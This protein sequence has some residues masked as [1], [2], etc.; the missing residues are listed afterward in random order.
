MKHTMVGLISLRRAVYILHTP[1]FHLPYRFTIM[2]YELPHDYRCVEIFKKKKNYYFFIWSV[3]HMVELNYLSAE[4]TTV[5]VK[6]FVCLCFSVC[7]CLFFVVV[8]VVLFSFC[9]FC[10]VFLQKLYVIRNI[11]ERTSDQFLNG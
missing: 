1:L 7:F 2:Q 11:N 3:N 5:K 10:F 4:S 6:F 9:F 8:V